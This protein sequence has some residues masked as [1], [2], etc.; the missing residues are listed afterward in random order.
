[1]LEISKAGFL[2]SRW[3]AKGSASE[4]LKHKPLLLFCLL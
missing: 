3:N 2:F 4:A 1:L